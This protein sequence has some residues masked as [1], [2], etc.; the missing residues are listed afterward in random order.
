MAVPC[1][2]F[3]DGGVPEKKSA[4]LMIYKENEKGK[5][6]CI[7]RA[8]INFSE[9]FGDQFRD[10]TVEW[11][12]TDDAGG[13]ICKSITFQ[14]TVTCPKAKYRPVFDQCVEWRAQKDEA[15][16][17]MQRMLAQTREV[18]KSEVVKSGAD[19]LDKNKEGS[20]AAA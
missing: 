15:E 7:A 19:F 18:S 5:E 10:G 2:Y 8:E 9:H 17:E 6:E 16:A 1:T 11:V 14:A 4:T 3:V 20:F 13:S 12:K